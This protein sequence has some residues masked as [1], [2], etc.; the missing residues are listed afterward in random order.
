[1]HINLEKFSK[2]MLR[3]NRGTSTQVKLPI[4]V[5]S[6]IVANYTR[7][8]QEYSKSMMLN[9]S[10]FL[11][12]RMSMDDYNTAQK[13][14]MKIAF[15]DAYKLGK[16]FGTGGLSQIDTTE[17]KFISYQVAKEM[18][19]MRN[20]AVD[21]QNQS[22]KMPYSRRMKMYTDSL[23]S[24]FGFGRLVYLPDDIKII[25]QL[26]VTD[27][28]CPDCL[29]FAARNPYTK[30]TLPGLP[31]SGNSRCLA[32]CLCNLRYFYQDNIVN[33]EYESL[34]LN[35]KNF[36]SKK[37]IPSEDEYKS[38]MG[39]REKFY[40]NYLMYQSTKET[41]Y[42]TDYQFLKRE[43]SEYV[44]KNNLYFP[45]DFPVARITKDFKDFKKVTSFALV[46]SVTLIE[47][48][49]FVSFIIGDK[50]M[51]GKVVRKFGDDVFIKTLESLEYVVKPTSTIIFKEIA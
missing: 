7:T 32:N 1:M 46:D 13:D 2:A 20:F 47:D 9:M 15:T 43:F 27:K 4:R 36:N 31:K 44:K 33:S 48:N 6:M 34:I 17:K 37:N 29:M 41:K 30:K 18:E 25:W 24:M 38:L 40:F 19:F 42:K 8:K 22:G 12:G 45:V 35:G 23:D 11:A 28:H 51:Y 26:G 49:D 39:L 10:N 5:T 16:Y 14:A 50:S 3:R 21:M